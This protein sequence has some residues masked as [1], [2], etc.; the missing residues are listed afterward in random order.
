VIPS[1]ARLEVPT[2]ADLNMGNIQMIELEDVF[3]QVDV[4]AR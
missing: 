1:L 3:V 2:E 4:R